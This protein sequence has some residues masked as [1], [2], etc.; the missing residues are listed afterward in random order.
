M[1]HKHEDI[2]RLEACEMWIWRRI[3]KIS[4]LEHAT[5]ESVLERIGMPRCLLNTIARTKTKW[6]EHV[7]RHDNMLYA[8]TCNRR[9]NGR[10]KNKR[11]KENDVLRYDEEGKGR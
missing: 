7:L 10:K 9:Q 2:K 6:I 5:N 3:L 1:D 8:E 11:K 4:W